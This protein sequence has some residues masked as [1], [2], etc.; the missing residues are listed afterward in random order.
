M[1]SGKWRPFCFGLNV[2]TIYKECW[3]RRTYQG[4]GQIITSQVFLECNYLSL[5]LVPTFAITVVDILWA[6][7]IFQNHISN[8]YAARNVFLYVVA[9]CH[10]YNHT[11]VSHSYTF[12]VMMTSS[13]GT[14]SIFTMNHF[15]TNVNNIFQAEPNRETYLQK[16]KLCCTSVTVDFLSIFFIKFIWNIY[17]SEWL[18][19]PCWYI[20]S[21]S[22]KKHMNPLR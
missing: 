3:T 19:Q 4:H 13:S 7:T 2:L 20:G 9:A 22:Y 17:Y 18:K 11:H 12:G 21:I 1:S 16:A 8:T 5:P 15:H 10:K 14:I 6:R